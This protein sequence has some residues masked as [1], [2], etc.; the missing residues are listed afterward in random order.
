M[1]QF[2]FNS[3]KNLNIEIKINQINQTLKGTKLDLL[4]SSTSISLSLT[5]FLSDYIYAN[6]IT[7]KAMHSLIR[8]CKDTS[9]ASLKFTYSFCL[10]KSFLIPSNLSI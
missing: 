5:L 4:T 7:I 10:I 3:L 8:F 9:F 2:N 6:K 1:I